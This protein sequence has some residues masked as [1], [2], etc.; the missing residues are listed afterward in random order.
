MRGNDRNQ[1]QDISLKEFVDIVLTGNDY[2]KEARIA[3]IKICA[4][5]GNCGSK[6]NNIINNAVLGR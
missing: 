3:S 2:L 5:C 1:T 6:I 4:R